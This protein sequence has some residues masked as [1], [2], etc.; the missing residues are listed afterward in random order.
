MPRV[1]SAD[2]QAYLL[3]FQKATHSLFAKLTF[4]FIFPHLK[5]RVAGLMLRAIDMP[6]WF[7]NA[8]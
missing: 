6:R 1:F 7:L 3:R 2:S 4:F 5:C 8:G